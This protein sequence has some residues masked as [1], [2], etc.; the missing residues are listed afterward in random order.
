MLL[1]G[2][3]DLR[4]QVEEQQAT[5]NTVTQLQA[6]A[7]REDIPRLKEFDGWVCRYCNNIARDVTANIVYTWSC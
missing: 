5:I 2:N 4:A 1:G 3:A 6:A 7:Q